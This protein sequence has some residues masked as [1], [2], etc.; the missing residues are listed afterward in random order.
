MILAGGCRRKLARLETD[1]ALFQYATVSVPDS[2]DGVFAGK[3]PD[4][5]VPNGADLD[6]ARAGDASWPGT[7][8]LAPA[9]RSHAF[10]SIASAASVSVE[11]VRVLS[12]VSGMTM[13]PS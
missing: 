6:T 4:N 8:Y 9:I 11:E 12:S 3:T 7:V 10:R 5:V 1:Q 13:R 2:A